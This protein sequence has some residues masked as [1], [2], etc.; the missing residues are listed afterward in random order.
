M[1]DLKKSIASVP[2]YVHEG[3]IARWERTNRRLTGLCVVLVV[4]LAVVVC[5]IL[6][7]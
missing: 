3:E 1:E 4:A 7:R 2:Y 5:F 6:R